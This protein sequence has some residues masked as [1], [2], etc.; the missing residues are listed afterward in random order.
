MRQQEQIRTWQ[1]QR[2]EADRK[3]QEEQRDRAQ[4]N[5]DERRRQDREYQEKQ[6]QADRQH[7]TDQAN[8]AFRRQFIIV[9]FSV[10]FA[11][12]LAWLTT[13]MKA[14]SPTQK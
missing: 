8:K 12:L 10:L 4:R 6:K 9:G 13:I 2:L 7:Q 1:E 5:D 14:D 11:S 3:F